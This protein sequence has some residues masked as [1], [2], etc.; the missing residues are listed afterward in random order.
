MKAG[1][2]TLPVL[3]FESKAGYPQRAVLEDRDEERN[4]SHS[5]GGNSE[6]PAAPAGLP[7]VPGLRGIHRRV[8]SELVEAIAKLLTP[9]TSGPGQPGSAQAAVDC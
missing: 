3:V 5:S 1:V 2:S 4:N 6:R 8:L 9:S 7:H